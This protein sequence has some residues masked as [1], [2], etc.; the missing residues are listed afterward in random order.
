RAARSAHGRGG[1]GRSRRVRPA[2]GR[3][4][5]VGRCGR[6]AGGRDRAPSVR[7]GRAG[8]GRRGG[9]RGDP[10]GGAGRGGGGRL[11]GGR[12]GRG[13]GA[14]AGYAGV[15]L[16][17]LVALGLVRR[18]AGAG[19]WLLA[20]APLAGVVGLALLPSALAVVAAPYAWLTRIWS[21]RPKGTGLLPPGTT[22][23]V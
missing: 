9:A 16:L 15:G 12:L 23:P 2:G 18:P 3:A 4:G 22:G 14:V 7:S 10:G 13:G 20:R 11:G 6:P 8:P 19:R 5:G 17:T 1:G 21:G